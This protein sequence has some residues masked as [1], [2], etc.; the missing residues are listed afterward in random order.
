MATEAHAFDVSPKEHKEIIEIYA[1]LREAEAKLIGPDGK[2]EIL[3][4]H[5]SPH[6]ADVVSHQHGLEQSCRTGKR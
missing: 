2:A 5:R 4:Q 6:H 3:P 1:K